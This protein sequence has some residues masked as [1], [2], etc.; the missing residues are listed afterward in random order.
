[1]AEGSRPSILRFSAVLSGTGTQN[2]KELA[3]FLCP[4]NTLLWSLEM[5]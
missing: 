3:T 4:S 1:M 5:V 2:K